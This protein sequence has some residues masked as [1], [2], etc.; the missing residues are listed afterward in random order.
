MITCIDYIPLHSD[1]GCHASAKPAN[2][3]RASVDRSAYATT[4]PL[5]ARQETYDRKREEQMGKEHQRWER[6][7]AEAAAEEM[8]MAT[9]RAAGLRGQQNKGS[10]HFNI[11][12]L[13]YHDT[14]QGYTLQ[15]TVCAPAALYVAGMRALESLATG[16]VVLDGRER[17]FT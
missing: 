9:V 4:S 13:G 7:A 5:N 11:I 2:T 16:L 17:L 12:T 14:P 10:E 3:H 15:Y 6:M 1:A 8:R